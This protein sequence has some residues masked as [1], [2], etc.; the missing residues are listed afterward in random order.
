MSVGTAAR[1]GDTIHEYLEK[2]KEVGPDKALELVLAETERQRIAAEAKDAEYRAKE[3]EYKTLAELEFG[4][5]GGIVKAN[6]AGLWR[7]AQSYTKSQS[8]P[9]HYRSCWMTDKNGK[10]ELDENG[11]RIW[12][13]RSHDCFIACQLAFRWRLDPLMV[14]QCSYVVH[15]KPG[16]EGKLVT[17]LINSSGK[18]RGRV[19]YRTGGTGKDRFCTAYAI[20]KETGEEVAATVTWAMVEAEGWLSKTGSK[21]RTIPELMFTYR[22]ATFLG[23]QYFPEVLLG[24]RTTDE[25]RDTDPEP[26]ETRPSRPQART[27]NDLASALETD[28]DPPAGAAVHANPISEVRLSP[29]EIDPSRPEEEQFVAPKFDLAM[30]KQQFDAA[31][32]LTAIGEISKAWPNSSVPEEH[33]SAM[34]GME[35]EARERISAARTKRQTAGA[36][37]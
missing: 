21:W 17:A 11:K 2:V 20:D 36:G 34:A 29:G 27:L 8:V 14:M 31:T 25:I 23:R 19:R 35:A 15:G 16:I 33:H 9:E 6:M 26:V 24:M 30:V 1:G 37:A 22:A 10:L 5:D 12:Q 28:V 3:I 7:L 4:E 32:T 13:D 18:I